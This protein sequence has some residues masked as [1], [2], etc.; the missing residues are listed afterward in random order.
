MKKS[1]SALLFLLCILTT[2]SARADGPLDEE[3]RDGI[4]N[5]INS[6]CLL[7]NIGNSGG[8]G[9][10]FNSSAYFKKIIN[11]GSTEDPDSVAAQNS[12]STGFM[13]GSNLA[14][15]SNFKFGDMFDSEGYSMTISQ[16]PLLD[17]VAEQVAR[18]SGTSFEDAKGKIQLLQNAGV[19]QQLG[20]A[21]A[22]AK[23]GEA[24]IAEKIF[25]TSDRDFS[26]SL[27][28]LTELHQGQNLLRSGIASMMGQNLRI[29]SN[30][31][32]ANEF[33]V[34]EQQKERKAADN[35]R[36]LKVAT[37]RVLAA[38]DKLFIENVAADGTILANQAPLPSA[39]PSPVPTRNSILE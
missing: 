25:E 29:Q 18:D 6:Q 9:S 5:Y 12:G 19:A 31:Q 15:S 36:L 27:E 39:V 13:L 33:Q 38:N 2:P 35:E 28:A 11:I 22:R 17:R 10:C 1:I 34:Q 16:N 3:E 20:A 24:V 14:V 8:F 26:S 23:A 37:Q 32:L 30:V 4:N 21:S 7:N